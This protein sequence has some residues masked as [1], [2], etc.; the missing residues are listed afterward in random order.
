MKQHRI[1]MSQR[2]YAEYLRSDHWLNIR[3]NVLRRHMLC[4]RCNS[5]PVIHVHHT[6]YRNIYN[7]RR[8][9]LVALCSGCHIKI[10]WA[11]EYG[12]LNK[13]HRKQ[14][15]VSLSDDALSGKI[16]RKVHRM[17]VDQ[18]LANRLNAASGFQQ[19]LICGRLKAR[20][21]VDF[22][23]WIGGK[24]T[25]NQ[26]GFIDYILRT[27]FSTLPYRKPKLPPSRRKYLILK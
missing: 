22:C 3:D 8:D 13:N 7:I 5:A 26:K 4:E 23:N 11:I 15:I 9:D 19:Q 20:R 24:I 10:H 27:T 14:D 17:V 6:R 12:Y 18:E 1:R 16:K 25:A 21:P 2:E